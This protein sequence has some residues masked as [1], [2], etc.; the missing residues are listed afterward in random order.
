M[1]DTQPA[2][3]GGIDKEFIFA[4]RVDDKLCSWAAVQ[5]LIGSDSSKSTGVIKVV[6]CF[7]DEEIGSLLRQGARGNLLPST[8]ERIVE[9]FSD[10]AVGANL[11]AQ[12]FANS[13][14][15]SAGRCLGKNELIGHE[16]IKAP[17]LDV[18]HGV[19]P[20][21]LNAYLA[22]HAPRLNVGVSFRPFPPD[23][24]V[25]LKSASDGHLMGQ[26]RAHDDGRCL[27]SDYAASGRQVQ[28]DAAALPDPQRQSK[29]RYSRTHALFRHGLPRRRG[30]YPSA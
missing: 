20:N 3:V 21:F 29:W 5:A 25:L 11:M 19:N 26:Q 28:R 4:G 13:Y 1:Y 2:C 15:V 7:D 22:Q 17:F 27:G 10:K 30:R 6:G 8:I 9:C 12:T 23:R 14:L 18:T 24:S 16:L